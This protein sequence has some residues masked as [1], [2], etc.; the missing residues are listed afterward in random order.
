MHGGVAHGDA[1]KHSRLE[2]TD[3]VATVPMPATSRHATTAI[4]S[5]SG[6][7]VSPKANPVQ[8]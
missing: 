2:T 5:D 4:R 7:F 6:R 1:L 8:I 3:L